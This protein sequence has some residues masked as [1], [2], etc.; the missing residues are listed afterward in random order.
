MYGEIFFKIAAELKK[1]EIQD[2]FVKLVQ[3]VMP[4][5]TAQ[6]VG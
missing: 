4:K 6:V 5:S 1:P 3:R 2:F